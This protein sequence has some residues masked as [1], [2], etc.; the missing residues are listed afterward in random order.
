MHSHFSLIGWS[1]SSVFLTSQLPHDCG[2]QSRVGNDVTNISICE[3][4]S[5]FRFAVSHCCVQLSSSPPV[6]FLARRRPDNSL[7]EEQ[8]DSSARA[9]VRAITLDAVFIA[10]RNDT[11]FTK[12]FYCFTTFRSLS[13]FPSRHTLRTHSKTTL[14]RKPPSLNCIN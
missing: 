1:L 3:N 9:R 11:F 13:P 14:Y 7:M 2:K 12:L 8:L 5:S 4:T 6:V 10:F